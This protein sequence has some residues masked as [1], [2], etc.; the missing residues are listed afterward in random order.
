MV[1]KTFS[2]IKYFFRDVPK[3]TIFISQIKKNYKTHVN[4]N[5]SISY[6]STE[7]MEDNK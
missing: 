4:K 2:A 7:E 3:S 1:E 5:E 6:V